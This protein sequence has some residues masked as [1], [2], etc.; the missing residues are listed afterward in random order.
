M[1]VVPDIEGLDE[2]TINNT[3]SSLGLVPV[4][5]YENS[6][7]FDIGEIISVNPA[8]GQSVEPGERVTVTISSGSSYVESE[9][10]MITWWNVGSGDDD[11][12]FYNPYI[13]DGSLFIEFSSV[14]LNKSFSWLDTYGNGYGGGVASL[15]DS[16]DITVPVKVHYDSIDVVSGESMALTI[17]VPLSEF[18]SDRPTTVYFDLIGVDQSGNQF[19]IYLSL[20]MTW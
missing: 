2:T 18:Q 7:S 20:S 12:T 17:E 14:T 5:E 9:N 6:D 8:I 19:H 3:L 1:L 11:W 4:I 16:F 13:E 10:A 15:T